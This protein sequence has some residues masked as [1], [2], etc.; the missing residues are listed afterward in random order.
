M[1]AY[2]FKAQ[3]A[4]PILAGTKQQTIRANRKRHARPGETLQLYTGMRTK[5][6]RLIG[7]AVC[8]ETQNVRLS[9]INGYVMLGSVGSGSALCRELLRTRADCDAF[10]RRDGF[11]DWKSLAEFWEANH[12]G[13]RFFDGVLIFWGDTLTTESEPT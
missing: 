9:F 7:R 5:H 2:S 11:E 1:V 3:F 8:Q 4:A 6:C 13:T 12:P 10:A